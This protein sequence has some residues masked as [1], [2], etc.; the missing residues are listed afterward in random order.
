MSMRYNVK[1]ESKLLDFLLQH[2]AR[3]Q[4]KLFLKYKQVDVNG[5][6]QSYFDFLLHEGDFVEIQKE[7][8]TSC[9]IDILYEDAE[10]IVIHK[11]SGLLSVSGGGEKEKTAYHMVGEYLKRKNKQARVF[12]VHRLDK[13]TSGVLLFAKNEVIK[14]IFQDQWNTMMQRREYIAIVEGI[15]KEKQGVIKNYLDES[16]TQQVYISTNTGKLAITKYHVLK[17]TEQYSQVEVLL[18]TG[19]KNQIRVHMQS[20]GHSIVND[21]KY[22]ALS[23]PLKRLGLHCHIVELVHPVSGE[24]MRFVAPIPLSFEEL[25]V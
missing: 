9:P 5:V 14:K 22:G 10:C 16:K 6:A 17:E 21:K 11:P 25:F 12:V 20:L 23:N 24:A 1:S 19:R 18:E 13:E 3:K 2:Y 8:R 4:V 7:G 15:L